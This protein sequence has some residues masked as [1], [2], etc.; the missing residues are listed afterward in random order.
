MVVHFFMF[1]WGRNRVKDNE[2]IGKLHWFETGFLI[3]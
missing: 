3:G 1:D 2:I